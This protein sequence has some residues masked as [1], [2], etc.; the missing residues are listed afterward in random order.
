MWHSNSGPDDLDCLVGLLATALM[1]DRSAASRLISS[2]VQQGCIQRVASQADG[3]SAAL[4]L[5]EHGRLVLAH[6]RH[7]QRQAFEYITR[8]R[9][10]AERLELARLLPRYVGSAT[11]HAPGTD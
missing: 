2:C 5:T 10:E 11:S 1:I 7:Q 9:P 8:D 4:R 3:R 6:S